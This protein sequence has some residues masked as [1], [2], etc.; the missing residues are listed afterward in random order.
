[1]L[2]LSLPPPQAA[3]KSA[4]KNSEQQESGFNQ[5]SGTMGCGA[6]FHGRAA[7]DGGA[8]FN[9]WRGASAAVSELVFGRL[10]TMEFMMEL[11][12]GWNIAKN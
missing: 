8:D 12:C 6:S 2:R 9:L 11:I 1:V 4:D 7:F 10:V 5:I 3:S